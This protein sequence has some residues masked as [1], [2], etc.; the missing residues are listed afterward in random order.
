MFRVTT[1]ATL[2][3]ACAERSG[4]QSPPRSSRRKTDAG[5]CVRADVH[6]HRELLRR[7]RKRN[8]EVGFQFDPNTWYAGISGSVGSK[9]APSRARKIDMN[10]DQPQLTPAGELSVRV[11]LWRLFWPRHVLLQSEPAADH[12]H[13]RAGGAV[14]YTPDSSSLPKMSWNEYEPQV[15]YEIWRRIRSRKMP[16]QFLLPAQNFSGRQR[17]DDMKF[18]F[19]R[20]AVGQPG[21]FFLAGH[22]RV[23]FSMDIAEQFSINLET[24][25]VAGPAKASTPG[26]GTSRSGSSGPDP[27]RRRAGGLPQHGGTVPGRHGNEQFHTAAGSGIFS[28]RRSSWIVPGPKSSVSLRFLA[29]RPESDLSTRFWRFVQRS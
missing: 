27:Q 8:A 20:N 1:G 26:A 6:Q 29:G 21:Q 3:L 28:V 19:S 13:E 14:I 9:Y 22:R 25:A 5:D 23:N 16:M 7:P 24:S 11:G 18:S 2:L 15:G 17:L 12:G 10:L 4:C